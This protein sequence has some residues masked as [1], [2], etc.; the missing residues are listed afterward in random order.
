[1]NSQFGLAIRLL[2]AGSVSCLPAAAISASFL[3]I[4]LFQ[5]SFE[6]YGHDGGL[7]I[8]QPFSDW[9]SARLRYYAGPETAYF[10]LSVNGNWVVKNMPLG[11]YQG[12]G[13]VDSV[14]F[15]FGLG[16]LNG[17]PLSNTNYGFSISD[18]LMGAAPAE[19]LAAA[20]SERKVVGGNGLGD[21]GKKP[22]PIP[23]PDKVPEGDEVVEGG[24]IKKPVNQDC[25]K[26]QC[27]PAAASNSLQTLNERFK[28]GIDPKL[29]TT[30]AL[31][32]P[33]GTTA[34]EGTKDNYPGKKR[35]YIK[36]HKLPL[37]VKV[38]NGFDEV[39]NS[40]K[41]Q[42]DVE[43]NMGPQGGD[44]LGHAA[45]VVGVWKLKSGN[46]IFDVVHDTEQGKQ[47]G[48]E[49][50]QIFYNSKTRTLGGIAW[51]E[52]RKIK[53]FVIESPCKVA[54]NKLESL[55]ELEICASAVPEP[56]SWIVM[57]AGFGMV[58]WALRRRR[59]Q[60]A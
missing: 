17:T 55:D 48:T 56:D 33:F 38:V 12:D 13:S 19:T 51:A 31:A 16:L 10:N 27:V 28:L 35:L 41:R 49:R 7:P 45:Y 29:I 8:L 58:G 53:N 3:D 42:W 39:L 15:E 25:G 11:D 36:N 21:P 44:N 60:P 46:Y 22:R 23:Q 34:A 40:V 18:G 26:N 14:M 32:V 6:T 50:Q 9:G 43:I 57:I 59:L 4:S 37:D 47:G 30:E 20:V 1:M 54:G 24:T 5:N 52:G 2:V